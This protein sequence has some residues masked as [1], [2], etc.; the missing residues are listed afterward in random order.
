M[1]SEYRKSHY[2]FI[3]VFMLFLCAMSIMLTIGAV[4]NTRQVHAVET[5]N[6]IYANCYQNC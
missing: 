2:R 1:A 3:L 6:E 5:Y 4:K